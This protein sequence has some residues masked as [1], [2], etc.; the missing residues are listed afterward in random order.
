MSTPG[1]LRDRSDAAATALAR[2]AHQLRRRGRL[3]GAQEL[4]G[5]ALAVLDGLPTAGPPQRAAM[6]AELHALALGIAVDGGR[7]EGI[8]AAA[9]AQG[10][11]LAGSAG[12][13]AARAAL[14]SARLHLEAGRVLVI[15]GQAAAARA[16]LEAAL[17]AGHGHTLEGE[18]G[19]LVAIRARAMLGALLCMQGGHAEGQRVLRH[20]LADAASY[21]NAQ[22]GSERSRILL[23]LCASDFEQ[24]R[25]DVARRWLEQAF[26]ELAPLARAGRSGAM[27][28]LGRAWHNLGSIQSRAGLLADAVSAY[29][30]ALDVYRRA[31]R[32]AA[33][34]GDATRLRASVANTT[35]NLGY[36]CFKG[37]EHEHAQRHLAKALK[38]YG[39]LLGA[40]PQ[41]RLD[42]A[43]AAINAAHLALRSGESARAAAQYRRALDTLDGGAGTEP[44]QRHA[45]ERANALFGMARAELALG[46]AAASAS[47]FEQAMALL[48]ERM[49]QGQL[50]HANAWLR[51]WVTQATALVDR[52]APMRARARAVAALVD[53]LRT[54]PVRAFGGDEEPLR[55]PREALA[56]IARWLD[57]QGVGPRRDEGIDAL[58]EAGLR[59]LVDF[60]AQLLSQ[61]SPDWLA[62]HEAPVRAWI[63]RLGATALAHPGAPTLLA[64]WFM[65]TRGQ[66]GQRIAEAAGGGERLSELRRSLQE[67][68]RIE[69]ELL[70]EAGPE[71]M[72]SILPPA[73]GATTS[74]PALAEERAA[75]WAALRLD[76]DRQ[77]GQA[78]RD[79]L[80]P[81]AARWDVEQLA[82]QL[83]QREMLVLVARLDEA[84]LVTVA[85]HAGLEC[86]PSVQCRVAELPS[87][88]VGRSCDAFV[89]AARLALRQDLALAAARHARVPRALDLRAAASPCTDDALAL[90]G[91]REV[92]ECAVGSMLDGLREAASLERIVLVPADDLH[93]LPWRR[94]LHRRKPS[95][96]VQVQP[97]V[98]AWVRCR[99]AVSGP[100]GGPG[101]LLSSRWP[102]WTL[103]AAV[104]AP[105]LDPLHWVA[106][107]RAL[108][109][110][111]WSEVGCVPTLWHPTPHTPA[112]HDALLVMGHGA[113]P[114]GR[115]APAGL[116]LEDG[117]LLSAHDLAAGIQG[118][119]E[120]VLLSVCVSAGTHDAFG[121][122]LGFLST[123]FDYRTRF[124]IGWLTEVADAAACLFSLALQ[125]SLREAMAGRRGIV[126]GE[127]F[128]ATCDALEGGRWPEGFGSWMQGQPLIDRAALPAAPPPA[129]QRML[130]WVIA[131]GE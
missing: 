94:L 80:L 4:A 30:E 2:R 34:R 66:R 107:E 72:A 24:F 13:A 87:H 116:E 27:A 98:G 45:A 50:H 130:P 12:P 63:T 35:M 59:H 33:R 110:R 103:A 67:M 126:W 96:R 43:R 37:G 85:V 39:K 100:G 29:E 111:L 10:A 75:R 46:R 102:A 122:P 60:T 108:S 125:F 88:L 55:V 118:G 86:R 7:F 121:E 19:A 84:R 82:T 104:R 114:R 92:A 106:V 68:G 89:A 90:A 79:G 99:A 58:A 42:T 54:P 48:R 41:L 115:L 18:P 78:V 57:E 40:N 83:Q 81:A 70:A 21:S 14:A 31:M 15:Q 36:T 53:A 93:L 113:A 119:F 71:P 5:Q 38:R 109:T 56:A 131:L 32:C 120:H 129:L 61:S 47:H 22:A 26:A 112:I 127:V 74:A 28:D 8:V 3:D 73:M 76:I 128:D 11:A 65:G 123:C 9:D 62:H 64:Q 77:R 51:G 124:G 17:V 95:L 6:R 117:G 1:A 16:R 105:D 44:P 52:R 23:S 69:A 49:L 101:G 97:T 91:L 20:A 25:L